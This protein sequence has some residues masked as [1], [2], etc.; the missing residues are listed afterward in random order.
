MKAVVLFLAGVVAMTLPACSSG[1]KSEQGAASAIPVKIG[2]PYHREDRQAVS[3]SGTTAAPD[4]PA[5][6]SFLVSGKV[7]QVGPREGDPVRK[8][9]LLA[10]VDPTDYRLAL[11][12]A[13]AQADM[14][15][16]ACERAE[17][18]HR[19]MKMLFDSKSLAPND[20]QKFRA[21]FES[22]RQQVEQAAA[23]EKLSRK[24]VADATLHA[25]VSGFIAK[26]AIEPGEMASPGRPVF[27]I[28]TLDTV[29]ISVGVPETDVHLVRA[30]QKAEVT[31]P[32]LPGR[33]FEG[34]VRLVN[35]SADP[36]TRT[37]MARISVPNPKHELRIGMVAEAHIRGDRT[38]KLL[39]LPVE[40]IVRDP[41]GATMV[42]VYYP[43]QGRA[44][45]KRVETGAMHGKEIEIKGLTGDEPV[46]L[47]GQERLR[48]GAPVSAIP[49]G[50]V[51]G[52]KTAAPEK[53]AR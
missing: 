33:S 38:V 49:A 6:V 39:T 23:S 48:D 41:Q 35:V 2:T 13:T 34:T 36:G 37:Y 40:A 50:E 47:A 10:S 46:I 28:V 26:R 25:P 42:Y 22:A 9:Q 53:G 43:A 12:T 3:V 31:L 45:A 7:I 27:E 20:Y 18:E 52:K 51:P 1:K 15:R 8:G 4:A 32:A 29:E 21:A 19:R 44:Y 11:A 30:G 24:H 14:A 17:D 16:V 5:N